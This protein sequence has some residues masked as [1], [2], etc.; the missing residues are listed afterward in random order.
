MEKKE[1]FEKKVCKF[2]NKKVGKTNLKILKKKLK[3]SKKKVKILK[4]KG[5]N[6]EE[7]TVFWKKNNYDSFIKNTTF[8]DFD[9]FQEN[10]AYII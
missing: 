9:L 10:L 1:N 7:K 4:K 3:I 2:W 6:F 8:D 5:K